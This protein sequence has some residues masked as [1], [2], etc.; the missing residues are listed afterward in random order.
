MVQSREGVQTLD[1]S[2]PEKLWVIHKSHPSIFIF[3]ERSF[4]EKESV[5]ETKE[6]IFKFEKET[7]NTARYQESGSAVIN[8]LY[9]QKSALGGSPPAEIS[10]TI[11][12][13]VPA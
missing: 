11:G 12:V 1:I 9:I 5:M 2:V 8:T 3:T 4:I 10:V 6:L 7:K 13:S